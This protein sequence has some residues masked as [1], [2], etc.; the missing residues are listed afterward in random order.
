MSDIVLPIHLILLALT[1]ICVVLAD[2]YGLAWILGKK[3]LLNE[4]TVLR[5]HYAV[6]IGLT[7][8]IATGILLF[9]PVREYLTNQS[10]SFLPKMIFVLALVINSFVIEKH[11]RVTTTKK[12]VDVSAKEKRVLFISGAISL[13]GWV[14]AFFS[15]FQQLPG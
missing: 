13:V 7:G 2:V 3:Q 10:N 4:K 14:G 11:I 9:W 6:T 12:F 1:A 8:M 15:A 5:L